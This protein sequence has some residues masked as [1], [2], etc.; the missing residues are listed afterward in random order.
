MIKFQLIGYALDPVDKKTPDG[1]LIDQSL[2]Y[3][4]NPTQS[5]TIFQYHVKS[6]VKCNV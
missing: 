2:T 6:F 1:D 3:H 5:N 4:R